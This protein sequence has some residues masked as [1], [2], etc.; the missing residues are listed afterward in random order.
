MARL[1]QTM[2]DYVVIAITPALIIALVG[3]LVF[4]LLAVFYQGEFAGRLHWVM[5]CFVFAA[6]LIGRISIEEGLERAMQFGIA[7]AIPVGIASSRFVEVQGTWLDQVGFLINWGLIALIWW[8]AHRLT[9]DC[10]VIDDD[11]DASGEGLLQT[12]GLEGKAED[13][14][15]KT[16]AAEREIEGTTIRPAFSP[17]S[18]R[19]LWQRY[20]ES[21]RRPHAPGLSVVYFSLAALPLF[22]I[23]QWFIPATN[24]GGRRWA[25]W[26]LCVYVASGLGL[27]LTTSFLGLRRYLRQRRVEM[28]TVMANLW[29]GIGGAMIVVLLVFAALLPRPSAE[30]A[31]SELPF[32]VGSP[33]QNASRF[34]PVQRE[35]TQDDQ[36]GT[37]PNRQPDESQETSSES[38]PPDQSNGSSGDDAGQTPPTSNSSG[39]SPGGSQQSK[40]SSGQSGAQKSNEERPKPPQADN[41]NS[42]PRESSSQ[43]TPNDSEQQADRAPQPPQ[44]QAKQGKAPESQSKGEPSDRRGQQQ[45]ELQRNNETQPAQPGGS[46]AA[47]QFP[48]VDTLIGGLAELLKWAFYVVVALFVLYVLWRSRAE[49]LAAIR[50]FLAALLDFWNGLWGGKRSVVMAADAEDV[51]IVVPPAPFSTYADPFATGI[52]SRYS[53]DELVRY[54]FEAFEAWSREHGCTRE[55]D[56][57]PH[58]LARDVA[59][60]NASIAVDARNLVELYARAAYAKGELPTQGLSIRGTEQLRQLWQRMQASGAR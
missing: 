43:Q 16:P 17:Q 23:G 26:L 56:Q 44:E 54:S 6:V 14:S 55:P 10:T 7:L 2:A 11:Q 9:W 49:V 31:I 36:P 52:A 57:T 47:S 18:R 15:A 24:L 51:R 32:S 35:G 12:A 42:P 33:K 40:S 45:S 27:L 37:A 22:G 46:S 19:G 38:S 30:Y 1:R 25:F 59:K 4:F 3:S 29:L 5:A 21:Q 13:T 39:E 28:P 20:L 48:L 50:A 34:A 58:E 8:C 60:L 41:S 53:L